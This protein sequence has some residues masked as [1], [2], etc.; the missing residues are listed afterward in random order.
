MFNGPMNRN[1]NGIPNFIKRKDD[2][3]VEKIN[4]KPTIGD[5][6][7]AQKFKKKMEDE[8]IKKMVEDPYY[9]PSIERNPF[10]D[11][12]KKNNEKRLQN[13][14]NKLDVFETYDDLEEEVIDDEFINAYSTE[15]QNDLFASDDINN[16][17]EKTFENDTD[18]LG[19]KASIKRIKRKE[20]KRRKKEEQLKKEEEKKYKEGLKTKPKYSEF[21][22]IIL[23]QTVCNYIEGKEQ[24]DNNKELSK[25]QIT[26]AVNE[27][28]Q[29][30]PE[31]FASLIN[32][33]LITSSDFKWKK[34]VFN[35][36]NILVSYYPNI[37]SPKIKYIINLDN[38][39]KIKI[40]DKVFVKSS[41][42]TDGAVYKD[43][44]GVVLIFCS[45]PK[46]D[47]KK[48]IA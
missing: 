4:N 31:E 18:V 43:K 26:E 27:L 33:K 37:E 22:K 13:Y 47:N 10:K 42:K 40:E 23:K 2:E 5:V 8:E 6:Y 46:Q 15:S 20:E 7:S 9:D 30:F 34:E 48:R 21:E 17:E 25:E 36:K 41:V 32:R 14:E 19:I 1:Y 16:D 24:F 44:D 38:Q 11:K 28:K 29:N 3:E 45:A 12:D 39:D 35:D